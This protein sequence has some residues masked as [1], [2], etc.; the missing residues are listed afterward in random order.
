[1]LEFKG[2]LH[3]ERHFIAILVLTCWL[4]G[5]VLPLL[6]GEVIASKVMMVF[7]Q[8]KQFDHLKAIGHS[9]QVVLLALDGK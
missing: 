4:V 5:A 9:S 6:L 1:M 7:N 3:L 8:R 2:K